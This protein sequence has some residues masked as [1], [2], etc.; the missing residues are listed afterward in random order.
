M[1]VERLLSAPGQVTINHWSVIKASAMHQRTN[2][3][4]PPSPFSRI[5][6][7]WTSC[8][9]SCHP[10][11]PSTAS[12]A[13][14]GTSDPTAPPAPWTTSPSPAPSTERATYKHSRFSS[15]PPLIPSSQLPPISPVWRESNLNPST[16]LLYA[17]FLSSFPLSNLNF[18]PIYPSYSQP[19]PSP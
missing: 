11:R 14:P 18:L 7:Q 5:T 8:A 13:W 17:L 1:P 12:A 19:C 3:T 16:V 2:H 9:G 6:S 4:S 15:P 10:S